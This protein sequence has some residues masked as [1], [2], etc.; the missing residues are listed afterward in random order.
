MAPQHASPDLPAAGR[1]S[2][3]LET[4]QY[5][6]QPLRRKEMASMDRSIACRRRLTFIPEAKG[7]SPANLSRVSA[8]DIAPSAASIREPDPHGRRGPK[9]RGW[10]RCHLNCFSGSG[11]TLPS[12]ANSGTR[13][14][15]GMAMLFVCTYGLSCSAIKTAKTCNVA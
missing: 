12:A 4:A 8:H 9:L 1:P 5:A 15:R 2:R 3:P 6:A 13:F 7:L 11:A 10:Q 14:P